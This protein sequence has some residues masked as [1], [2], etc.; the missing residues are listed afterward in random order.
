MDSVE[1][2]VPYTSDADK[3]RRDS[4][5][6]ENLLLRIDQVKHAATLFNIIKD[7]IRH[8]LTVKAFNE[9]QVPDSLDFV[10]IEKKHWSR[11]Q[12]AVGDLNKKTEEPGNEGVRKQFLRYMEE[13]P[14]FSDEIPKTEQ[15][16]C[17]HNIKDY[18]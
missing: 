12:N 11:I 17:I 8:Y 6:V 9:S 16:L 13:F 10:F 2:H 4:E 14:Q 3:I 15:I 5:Y 7:I 1:K 18:K